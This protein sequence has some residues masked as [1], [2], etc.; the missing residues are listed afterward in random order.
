MD[1]VDCYKDL[2]ILFDTGFKLHKHA[3]EAAM[4]ANRIFARRGFIN[5]NESG[6]F[7]SM[8]W[9]ILEYENIIWG[10]NYVL[11]QIKLQADNAMQQNLYR[12]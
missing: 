5:L 9:P 12:L 7:K 11:D 4:K 2:G 10:P 6:L 8:V 1:S 3:S